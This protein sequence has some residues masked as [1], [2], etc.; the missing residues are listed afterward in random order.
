MDIETLK[1]AL[2]NSWN[3]DTCYPP[4]EKDWSPKNPT[5]GQCYSTALV[6]NDYF[7]GELLQAEFEDGTGHFWNLIENKELDLTRSQFDEDEIIPK[8]TIHTR[9]E[10]ENN[11]GYEEYNR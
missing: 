9:K 6:V 3:K 2:L 5:Y 4:M 10:I 1:K 11:P 8:P 7:G